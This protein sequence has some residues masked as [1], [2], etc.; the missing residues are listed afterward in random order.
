MEYIDK[1]LKAEVSQAMGEEVLA[2]T[3]VERAGTSSNVLTLSLI[4]A[5]AG[6]AIGGAIGGLIEGTIKASR[7]PRVNQESVQVNLPDSMWAAVGPT[8]FGLFTTKATGFLHASLGDI[9]LLIP[10][11]EVTSFDL[12]GGIV[13]RKLKVTLA[14]GLQLNLQVRFAFRGQAKR[15]AA[16]LTSPTCSAPLVA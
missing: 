15:I 4:G 11:N 3:L 16:H 12:G 1:R 8:K 2:S 10:K 5:F 9:V 13:T 6:G 14:N 7:T